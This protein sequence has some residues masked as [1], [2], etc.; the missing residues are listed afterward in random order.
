MQNVTFDFRLA[1]STG[2]TIADQDGTEL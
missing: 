2:V 1:D